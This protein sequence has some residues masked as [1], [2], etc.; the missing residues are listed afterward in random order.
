M[1]HSISDSPLCKVSSRLP[2]PNA[3]QRPFPIALMQSVKCSLFTAVDL[4]QL[5]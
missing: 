4:M 3:R 2:R 5:S 1:P